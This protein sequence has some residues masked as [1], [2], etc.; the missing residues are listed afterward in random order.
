[1]RT[2]VGGLGRGERKKDRRARRED[3]R[4]RRGSVE[5]EGGMSRRLVG[6]RGGRREG[7]KVRK[8]MERERKRLGGRDGVGG[9]SLGV[10]K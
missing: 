2:R 6:V 5:G 9:G 7:G 8:K 10:L 4:S 1:M 3:E